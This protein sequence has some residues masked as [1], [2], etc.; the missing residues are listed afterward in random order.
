MDENNEFI[1]SRVGEDQQVLHERF[2]QWGYLYIKAY[3]EKKKCQQ[4]LAGLSA[5]LAPHIVLSDRDGLP[6][7]RGAPVFSTNL[8]PHHGWRI[9]HLCWDNIYAGWNAQQYHYYWKDYPNLF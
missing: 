9:G 6:A 1:T 5:E 8:E 3:V 2:Q 4:L 7:L